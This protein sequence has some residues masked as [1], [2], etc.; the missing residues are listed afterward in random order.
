MEPDKQS[1]IPGQSPCICG[2]LRRASRVVTK[3]YDHYLQPIDIKITQYSLLLA[4]Q[5]M[6]SVTI[7]Q[8]ADEVMLERTT[9]T[10]NLKILADKNFITMQQGRDKRAKHVSL[11]DEGA[12][13]IDEARP[14]WANAQEYLFNE[15]GLDQSVDLLNELG[16][17]V[18]MLRT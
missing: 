13:R 15:I 16:R 18:N 7:S 12:A 14:L 3:I 6:E 17:I 11:T 9:C 2:N 5:R 1:I 4:I 8:L 10:R